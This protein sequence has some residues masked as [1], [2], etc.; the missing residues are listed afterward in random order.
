M[1]D[2][3]LELSASEREALPPDS[4][5]KIDAILQKALKARQLEAELAKFN[6]AAEQETYELNQRLEEA[7]RN[8]DTTLKQNEELRL[9]FEQIESARNERIRVLQEVEADRDRLSIQKGEL[10]RD[11]DLQKSEK[12]ELTSLISRKT[13]ETETL[14]GENVTLKEQLKA[15]TIEKCQTQIKL[16]EVQ[17]RELALEYREKRWQQDKELIENEKSWYSAELRTREEQIYNLRKELSSKEVKHQTKLASCQDELSQIRF[18]LDDAEAKVSGQ[19]AQIEELTQKLKE[20]SDERTKLREDMEME[21]RSKDKLCEVY[22]ESADTAEGKVVELTETLEKIQNLYEESKQSYF[23]IQEEMNHLRNEFRSEL[24]QKQSQLASTEDELEKA[25]ELLRSKHRVMLTDEEVAALSPAAASAS[26]LIKSGLSLTGI[27]RDHCKVVEELEQQR[28]ENKRLEQYFQE[29]VSDIEKKAPIMKQQRDDYIRTLDVCENLKAQLADVGNERQKLLAEKDAVA[30]ELAYTKAELERHQ[31][32]NHDLSAQV[33]QLLHVLERTRMAEAGDVD[34]NDDLFLFR[35]IEDLQA[36]NQQL[37]S[38]LREAEAKRE[39][40]IQAAHDAEMEK[41]KGELSTALSELESFKEHREKQNTVIQTICEQRDTYK[42][43]LAETKSAEENV[44]KQVTVQSTAELAELQS[45]CERLSRDLELYRNEK[46]E[47]D[48]LYQSKIEQQ[49]KEL[50]ELKRV[51]GKLEGDMEY[52]NQRFKILQRNDETHKKE[53]ES[54][55]ERLAAS[56]A[57]ARATEERV[58]D[59]TREL[60]DGRD[61]LARLRVENRSLTDQLYSAKGSERR[62]QSE[63]E[64]VRKGS[65]NNEMLASTLQELQS[66]LQRVEEEKALKIQSTLDAVQKERDNLQAFVN[67][68]TDQH[69]VY[70]SDTK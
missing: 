69:R 50:A 10:Q 9:R 36:K 59:A 25:N 39:E 38:A 28:L 55:R 31:R 42:R 12:L 29:L 22:K 26:R 19:A 57:Q 8:L 33:R 3:L 40:M 17:S 7:N 45:R 51:N 70:V 67:N 5:Q 18:K 6:V 46:K 2:T 41:M 60:L 56:Q 58:N 62:L 64:I 44:E 35:S 48:K 24:E 34:A 21:L 53:V 43:L 63:L 52:H 65:Y 13:Q 27:Y 11:N 4:R 14:Q 68:M 54:L 49:Y 1:S 16:D 32:D 37:M 23:G 47:S 66:R 30:R 61:Q 20:A 15:L